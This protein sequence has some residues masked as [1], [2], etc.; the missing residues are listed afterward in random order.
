MKTDLKI[1]QLMVVKKLEKCNNCGVEVS[2]ENYFL[3][4][5]LCEK[6]Y[7]ENLEKDEQFRNI[8]V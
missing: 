1:L 3:N 6:C 2:E 5:G 7:R 8:N 4:D